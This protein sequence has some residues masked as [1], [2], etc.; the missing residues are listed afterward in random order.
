[1][2]FYIWGDGVIWRVPHSVIQKARQGGGLLDGGTM[3]AV[4]YNWRRGKWPQS[5][6]PKGIHAVC[7]GGLVGSSGVHL[8]HYD[9]LDD[10]LEEWK[11]VVLANV[12]AP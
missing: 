3:M 8:V 7:D 5:Q 1:M 2:R 6:L 9:Y 12:G 11:R 10:V 4:R